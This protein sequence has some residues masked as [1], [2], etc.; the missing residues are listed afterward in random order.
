M[1]QA[2]PCT[3]RKGSIVLDEII[4]AGQHGGIASTTA[5]TIAT[6]HR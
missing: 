4:V 2:V 3:I 5:T 1:S 6:Q